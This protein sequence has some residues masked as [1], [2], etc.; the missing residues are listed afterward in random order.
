MNTAKKNH[1][2]PGTLKDALDV[3]D[4]T[5]KEEDM[6][7]CYFKERDGEMERVAI[8]SVVPDSQ[9]SYQFGM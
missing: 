5:A 3:I 8:K 1:R 7:Y 9:K 6:D 2:W 4:R